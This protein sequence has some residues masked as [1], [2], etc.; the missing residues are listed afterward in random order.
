[1]IELRHRYGRCSTIRQRALVTVVGLASAFQPPLA[2]ASSPVPIPN[3]SFEIPSTPF[4][5]TEV[6]SWQ[7]TPRPDDYD[8]SGGFLWDQLCGVFRNTAVTSPDHITNLDGSQALYLFAVPQVGLLMDGTGPDG[9][10]PASFTIG[11]SATLTVSV[12]GG[13]GNMRE[14]ASLR[15]ELYY[16]DESGERHGAASTTIVHSAA[17]F[18]TNT[19]LVEFSTSVPVVLPEDPWAGRRLGIALLSGVTKE[20][21]LE[22]GYWDLDH[23]RLHVNRGDSFSLAVTPEPEA[24]RIAWPGENGLQYQVQTSTNLVTWSDLGPLRPG[25]G[26]NLEVVLPTTP[27][28]ITFVRVASAPLR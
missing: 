9:A 23:I 27:E 2:A 11:E 7:K 20:S 10:F 16:L 14:G 6:G 19:R 17:I 18:P 21:G 22:G 13:G 26:T 15:A 24:L 12:I 8:E 25:S 3:G 5:S 28:D 4:V 1:M